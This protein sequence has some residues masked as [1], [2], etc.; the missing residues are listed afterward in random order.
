MVKNKPDQSFLNLWNLSFGFFGVQIAYALQS[1]NISRIFAT[2]GADPHSLSYF[3]ILPPLMGIIVQPLVGAASDRTWNRLGRRLPYLVLGVAIAVVVMCLLPNAGSFGLTVGGAMIFGFIALMFL[4][5][6]INMAMQPFKMLVGDMVNERQKGLAYS[7]Q[8]FLCNAGSVVGYVAPFV[9][10]WFLSNT[11]PAGEVP[12]TVTWAF[13]LGAFILLLCVVY[14]FAKVKEMPPHEYAAFHGI[15]EDKNGNAPK[16]NM[17][18]L[19]VKAPK[20]FWTVGLVQFFC[21]AA[22]LYMWTYSTDAVASQAF[23]APSMQQV[24]SIT[25]DGQEYN[26]K[27]IFNGEQPV[28]ENGRLALGGVKIDGE[29]THP[30][31]LIA[32]GDTIVDG[33][34][35]V[36]ADGVEKVNPHGGLIAEAGA[37]L[38]V[39]GREMIVS[40]RAEAVSALTLALADEG[41]S[42]T[43]A[44]I[45]KLDANTGRYILEETSQV[46]AA[47]G[48]ISVNYKTVLNPATKAYQSAGGWNGNL[49]AIQAIAAVLWTVVL[50]GFRRRKLG[51]SLSLLI[52]ASGFVSVFFIHNQYVLGISYALMGCAWAAM[53]SMPFTILTNALSGGNIGTYLGLFNW[54]ITIPQIVAAL[55]GGA[56]LHCFPPA[57]NGAPLTVGMLVVSGVLLAIGSVA[58]WNIKETFGSRSSSPAEAMVETQMGTDADI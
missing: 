38:V 26:D 52:G 2:L 18:R 10:A 49:L 19:L 7:I 58:V 3:W 36:V 16:E 34:C 15:S 50:A 24:T 28:L 42:L 48:E 25:V 55:C 1:A 32:G 56:V 11:A 14:T 39:D 40:D 9:L 33:G 43:L 45:A 41:T 13:Y 29:L 46:P 51:Y 20:V 12:A 8:S 6:S 54:T 44:H 5:T 30:D 27:Y 35:L 53:L 37:K 22:F 47:S 4:D 17:F 21:W 57:A 23:G 31:V